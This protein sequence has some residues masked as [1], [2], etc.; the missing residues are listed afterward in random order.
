[1]KKVNLILP[2]D[3]MVRETLDLVKGSLLTQVTPVPLNL[4]YHCAKFD[5][6]KIVEIEI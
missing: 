6:E 1:M 3:Q 5:A 4:S 2:R